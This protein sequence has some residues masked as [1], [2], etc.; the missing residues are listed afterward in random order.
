MTYLKLPDGYL[1]IEDSAVIPNYAPGN[2]DW[3]ALQVWLESGNTAVD[4]TPQ[5]LLGEIDRKQQENSAEAMRRLDIYVAGRSS[6]EII[7]WSPK[8]EDSRRFLLNRDL[9]DV[10]ALAAEAAQ[11]FAV[12]TSVD[13]E[14]A[15][16]RLANIILEKEAALKFAAAIVVG[17]RGRI[18]QE[19]SC[20]TTLQAV[21]SYSVSDRWMQLLNQ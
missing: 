1:R 10:V 3:E 5:T 18:A 17:T 13:I 16:A 4:Q 6:A 9:S 14:A 20:L 7:S 11:T 8:A 15:T 19:L 12:K 21:Q 2:R